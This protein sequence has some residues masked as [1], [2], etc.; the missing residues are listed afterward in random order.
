MSLWS[1]NSSPS[2][3]RK[4]FPQQKNTILWLYNAQEEP[5]GDAVLMSVLKAIAESQGAASKEYT[6]GSAS[7]ILKTLI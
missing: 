7:S 1:F 3:D 6:M 4:A 5:Y 2:A